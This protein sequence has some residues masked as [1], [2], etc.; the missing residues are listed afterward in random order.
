M[1]F[2]HAREVVGGIIERNW[3]GLDSA[4][5]VKKRTNEIYVQ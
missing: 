4:A 3:F 5:I 2:H 1:E